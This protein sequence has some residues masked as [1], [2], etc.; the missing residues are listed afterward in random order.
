M[1][2]A[3]QARDGERLPFTATVERFGKRR[4]WRGEEE[5]I[6]LKNVRFETGALAADHL[7]WPAGDWTTGLQSGDHITFTARVN[8]YVKGYRGRNE[9]R[10]DDTPLELD[11]RLTRPTQVRIIASPP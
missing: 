8:A 11:Y 2:T 10:Q 9:F 1:R 6:L 4:G 7:W 3:L 5:T